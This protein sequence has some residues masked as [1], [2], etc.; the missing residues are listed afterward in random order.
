MYI[1]IYIYMYIYI[2]IHMYVCMYIYIYIYVLQRDVPLRT[3]R[4]KHTAKPLARKRDEVPVGLS[5]LPTWPA[6]T[7]IS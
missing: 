2:Y 1:Y 5:Y 3:S 6:P 7:D 4:C